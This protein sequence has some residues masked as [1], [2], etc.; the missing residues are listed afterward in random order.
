MTLVEQHEEAGLWRNPSWIPGT[1]GVFALVIGVSDYLHLK[2]DQNS[3]QMGSLY[4]SALTAFRFFEW[5]GSL[6]RLEGVPL[7][8]CRLL[9]SPTAAELAYE[10]RLTVHSRLPDFDN[11]SAAI[12]QWFNEMNLLTPRVAEASRSVFFFSGHGL[13]ITEEMQ[14]LLPVD[15]LRPPV[16]QYNRA[17]GTNNL[18]RGL[19]GLKVNRHFLFMDACR[20]DHDNLQQYDPLE[21]API[22]NQPRGAARNPR[23]LVPLFF[24]SA[25]GRESFQPRDPKDGLSLFGSALLEGLRGT[26]PRLDCDEHRCLISLDP[27]LGYC[28]ERIPRIAIDSFHEEIEQEVRLAGDYVQDPVTEVPPPSVPPPTLGSRP[29]PPGTGPDDRFTVQPPVPPN[30]RPDDFNQAHQVFGS[31]RVTDPFLNARV[32]SYASGRW[33]ERGNDFIIH[34]VRYTQSRRVYE[35]DFSLTDQHYSDSIYWL[36]LEDQE[37]TFGVIVPG[38][39]QN[40]RFELTLELSQGDVYPELGHFTR[41]ALNLAEGSKKPYATLARAWNA[42]RNSTLD[43]ATKIILSDVSAK[44]L[45]RVLYEKVEAP[46][47]AAIAGLLLV[48]AQV[49]PRLHHWLRNVAFQFPWFADG[50]ALWAEQ[51]LR[52]RPESHEARVEALEHLLQLDQRE[53][54]LLAE[55]L[56]ITY[57]RLL[58]F[59]DDPEF[60]TDNR[61]RDTMT[62]LVNRYRSAIGRAR[63]GG[64]FTVWAGA[65]N[66]LIPEIILRHYEPPKAVRPKVSFVAEELN[67]VEAKQEP[68][69]YLGM[70]E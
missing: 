44:D 54:P 30:W 51:L 36:Q 37:R 59:E 52:E 23:A 49:W 60:L 64:L 35:V 29:N 63:P 18:R 19:K 58:E 11:C 56:A 34:A 47:G 50:A 27:L 10:P 70:E 65:R 41:I 68:Q 46:L 7:A 61:K 55:V 9:V 6:Y 16:M 2:K 8:S 24:S 33:L 32:F 1:P 20:N 21:G 4:V 67:V 43:S 57:S 53:L 38:V 62:R 25:A 15:Y 12:V 28:K 3:M 48:K 5:L 13:E 39:R 22:L 17:I 42:Y 31:E 26:G 14:V 66:T 45:E 69:K 40:V